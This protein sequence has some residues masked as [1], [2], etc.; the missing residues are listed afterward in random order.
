MP[1]PT[2]PKEM[3]RHIAIG[4]AGHVDHG[5]T[6]LVRQL[7]GIDTDRMPEEKRRGLSIEPGI[8]PLSLPSGL[9]VSLV[10][11]PGHRDFLKNAIR[12]LCSVDMGILVVAADDGVMPQ[13]IDHLHVLNFLKAR[14]GLV[15]LSKSDLVDE[16]TLELAE[17]EISDLTRGTF[18]ENKPAIP[19]SGITG[20]GAPGILDCISS[21]INQIK[22]HNPE[23]PFRMWIDQSRTVPG[24]GTVVSGTILS[25]TINCDDTVQIMPSGREVKVRFIETH[26]QRVDR[27]VAGQ[28]VGINLNRIPVEEAQVG[29]ELSSPETIS[30]SKMI[31]VELRLLKN[32][33]RP[34]HKRQIV[35]LY[36]GSKYTQALVALMEAD[37]LYP[38]QTGLAQLRLREPI[39]IC[40]QDTFL[41]S[42]MNQPSVVGGGTILETARDKF[43]DVKAETT[44]NYL[45]YLQSGDVKGVL[46]QYF[47]RYPWTPV[48]SNNIANVTGLPV[49][50][51]QKQVQLG[52]KHG[53]F[54]SLNGLGYIDRN[55]LSALQ[56]R[57]LDVVTSILSEDAFKQGISS[58]EIR[59]R[60][61]PVLDEPLFEKIIGKL[62]DDNRLIKTDEGYRV[63]NV[64]SRLSSHQGEI[65]R[66]LLNFA[67]CCGYAT[68]SP[69]TFHKLNSS[70]LD[71][72]SIQR[73]INFLCS[74][75]KLVKLN[76]GRFLNSEVLPEIK[77]KIRSLILQKGN[78]SIQ[79]AKTVLG[80]GRSKGL[81]VLDYL[82]RIGFT[83][84]V[85]DLRVLRL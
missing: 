73:A 67:R 74:Q 63:P 53:K 48:T 85:G 66:S 7:T 39:A 43:R 41:V 20:K 70:N 71:Y 10:D 35:K 55:G 75:N 59:T 13:T 6:K 68:F 34:I 80:Y 76:D 61:N 36:I 62:C 31:N 17:M 46:Q 30:A 65:I 42:T 11:V 83:E 69:G 77:D 12:G 38:D 29:M 26:H 49:Q 58:N 15:V 33:T 51:I 81:P 3:D 9:S 54:I 16:E 21:E 57:I 27:A 5:K 50:E 1:S 24:F 22:P 72:G 8:A 44:L 37:H 47:I 79:D 18:L 56:T 32:A 2:E 64:T 40:P 78:L 84:R 60:M 25:G 23:A 14:T 4:I 52:S 28:R 82:D 19:F 45:K